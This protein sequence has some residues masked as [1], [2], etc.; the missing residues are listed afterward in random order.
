MP[1]PVYRPGGRAPTPDPAGG[2]HD[3]SYEHDACGVGFVARLH[4]PASH[5]VV[6]RGIE[7]LLRMEHR[8]A[9]GADPET[10]DGAGVLIQVPDAFLRDEVDFELPPAGAYGVA[11][12]FLPR[13]EAARADA[14]AA[15]ETAVAA[16]E[17]D[18]VGWREVPVEPTACGRTAAA[19]APHVAQLFVSAPAGGAVDQDALERHLYVA[20]RVAEHALVPGFAIP[21]CSSRTLVYKGMLTA[22][23]LPRYF[24]DLRDARVVSRMA[25]V[26]SRFSTNTF[27]SWELAHPYRMLAHNGEINTL[28]GNR[29]W[30]RAREALLA[31]P[32]FG[33]DVRKL[34]PVLADDISDS[35]ALDAAFELLTLGGRSMAH[36]ISMLIPEA[37]QGRGELPADVNDFFAYHGSLIEPWDGPAAV[38]FSDGRAIGATLDRNGLRPGRWLHTRDGWVVFGSETGV[39]PVP[40]EEVVGKG[41]LH[42]GKLF[43]V[44]LERERVVPD[45]EL[46]REL[47]AR[48]P[49]GEWLAVRAVRIED[50]P[51]KSPRVPRVEPLRARQLAFGW[52]DEDVR[53]LLAPAAREGV[54]P[55]G[56]MGNDTALAVLSDSRPSLFS[57][58]KQLFAQVTNPAIDPI[59]ESI[60]MSLQ[61]CVGPEINLL[62]ETPDHC[63]QLVMAQPIL[64]SAELEQLR[65]VDHDVFE[66][67]TIDTTWPVREG[68]RGLERRLEEICATASELVA[69]GMTILILSDRN[70]GPERA[71]IPS[72]LATGAVHHHLVRDATR[73]RCGLVVETGEAREVHHLACLIGYGAAAV[74]PYLMFESLGM[75]HREERLG[76]IDLETAEANVVKAIGKGLLKV[77]SKMGI[78]TMRSYTGAQIFEAIGLDRELVDRHFTG[79]PSRIGGVGFDVLAGEALDRHRRA[80]PAA[81]SELLPPGGIYAWRRDGEFHGWNPETIANLQHAARGED[82]PDSYERFRRYVNDVAVRSSTLR[83]LL[84]F[85]DDVEPVPLDEVEPAKEIVKRFKSGG[86]SLGALSPEAHEGLAVAM[87]RLGGKSNTGEGGED[88]ARFADERRSAIKQ[89]A[90]GRFGVTVDYLVNADEIQIK[91]AQGAKP[92][93]GGQL[94]GHKVDA[95]IAGLRHSTAGVTLISPPPHHDIYS[96]EDLKQLIYDLRTAN[97][98]ARVSVKLVSEVGVGTVAAGVAK[99]NADHVVIAG[100]DGGT[101]ASP[102]SSIQH[103]GIPWEIGL[104]ETQQT[105]LKNDLRSRIV[106]ETDGQMRTGRDVMVAALLGADEYGFSTAPLIALGCVMMRVCH[107]NTC[108]VGVATQDPELRRRF[109]GQPDHVVD[110]LFMVAEEAREIMASLGLRSLDE[111]IGHT[112]LLEPDPGV[113]HWKG[114]SVDLSALLVVPEEAADGRPRHRTRPPDPVL[115]GA[116]GHELIDACLPAIERDEPVSLRRPI[117]N[118]HRAVGGLLSSAITRARGPEGLPEGTVDI[119]LDGSAG[120]SFGAWL[121][122]GVTL[123]L[124]GDANDYVGK[125]LS[126]GT[127]IVRPGPGATFVASKNV[128]VGNTVL[129][130]ATSGRAFFNGLAGERFAVRNSGAHAVV[131]GVGDHGC[132]YMTG[133]R[134]VVIGP[135][136]LNFGAGMSGGIA[137]VLDVDG[138][139]AGR[140]N[141]ELVDVDEPAEA[142]LD[143]VHALVAEHFERTGSRAA[144]ALL[145]DWDAESARFAKVMPRDYKRALAELAKAA[146]AETTT[147]TPA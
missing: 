3:Q 13:D 91:V 42:P 63:H 86:M 140:C 35:G 114:R 107:L 106:V 105:L 142:D 117:E 112:E 136:G 130:G 66:A 46:K 19:C 61:A 122:P 78:S 121:A 29:N 83:G 71:P 49:Y 40:E 38:A 75:L 84:R 15:L 119:E 53:V 88:P 89:V 120:Q 72:L 4:A 67:R 134:I 9:E 25:L 24:P 111:A 60:V 2:L 70:M 135:T 14:V 18:V 95:Y 76:G 90:S 73:L 143:E 79:T 85:R 59:R 30:M 96:I 21:S 125:G 115:E 17:L 8:G 102:Q 62:G 51:D 31:S 28:R 103:A 65:Q 34:V 20:R 110:Y 43:L 44:D 68:T 139:F 87:N 48:Q 26:H 52:S 56:S 124:N 1:H 77:L 145:D 137:Y 64:R 94:P 74:N 82:G 22:P 113:D 37:Y 58:F 81:E 10:G 5:A 27:P 39:L 80:Y 7:V 50:L 147:A 101:G 16:Q 129:Y 69:D 118:E 92:G 138:G 123:T 97:P 12:C 126:G 141:T 144:A 133:G 108:P 127:V 132:E 36:A 104:A 57:Y 33:D 116:V 41:R 6:E 131:E 100:H 109:A 99:A 98:D 146:A 128:I 32:L 11:M 45:G 23:Q 54:E 93:E 47:A 55:T